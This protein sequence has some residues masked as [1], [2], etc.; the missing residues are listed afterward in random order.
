MLTQLSTVKNRLGI[1]PAD[2]KDDDLLT[3]A[4]NA[5]SAR[6]DME[7]KRMFA[8]TVNDAHEFNPTE[9]EVVP[10]CY[11]IESVTRF[12]LKTSEDEGWVA[13]TD[14]SFLLRRN[15]VIGLEEGL[16]SARQQAR[17]IYTGGYVLPGGTV[18]AGQTALPADLE[19]AAIEMVTFWYQNRDRVGVNRV[20]PKGG[21]FEEF[22]DIDLVPSVR[23]A[24]EKYERWRM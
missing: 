20:W 15:C 4:I 5:I 14:V 1:D 11:P 6:F 23:A 10:R 18:G 12:E 19:T 24:L 3:R 9:I 16:G 17:V 8:R 21:L 13:Q 7:C 22:Q 2:I